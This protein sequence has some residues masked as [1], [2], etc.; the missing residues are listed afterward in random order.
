[1]PG[2]SG[3]GALIGFES[4]IGTVHRKESP[5]GTGEACRQSTPELSRSA[6]GIRGVRYLAGNACPNFTLA[7]FE[8]TSVSLQPVAV[9]S[10]LAGILAVGATL[11]LS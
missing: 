10:G 1:M 6:R 4:N 9:S 5:F 8:R 11:D 2:W 3:E 7:V